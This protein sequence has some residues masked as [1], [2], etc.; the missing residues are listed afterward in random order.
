MERKLYRSTT[1]VKISG[2]CAG[3]AKYL[4]VDVTIIRLAWVFLTCFT[5]FFAGILMYVA[6][7]LII[8]MEPDYIDV[9]YKEKQ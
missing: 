4:N 6:C 9:Q 7:A 5:A 1:D 3:I 8:P 2:V